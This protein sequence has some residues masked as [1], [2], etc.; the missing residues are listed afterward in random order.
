RSEFDATALA[1]GRGGR[2]TTNPGR[3][4]TVPGHNMTRAPDR[5]PLRRKKSPTSAK[6]SRRLVEP[7][8]RRVNRA[9]ASSNVEACPA[10]RLGSAIFATPRAPE[11]ARF[12]EASAL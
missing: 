9:L 6:G 4:T 8:G 12:L 5:V 11:R 2:R 3:G 10:L 7:K 1:A